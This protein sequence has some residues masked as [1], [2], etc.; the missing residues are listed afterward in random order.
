MKIITEIK[1]I[2]NLDQN[3]ADGLIFNHQYLSDTHTD[4]LTNEEVIKLVEYGK[5]N[6]KMI[7]ANVNRIFTE[8]EIQKAFEEI[9]ELLNLGVEYFVFSDVGIYQ[10]FYEKNLHHNLIYNARTM[11]TNY[12]DAQ[13]WKENGVYAYFISNEIPLEDIIEISKVGNGALNVY[14]YHQIF[15]SKR[16]LVSLYYAHRQ[17]ENRFQNH[18]LMLVEEN[19][20]KKYPITETPYGTYI[21]SPYKYAIYTE[22]EKLRSLKLILISGRFINEENLQKVI[23]LY[24]LGIEN[25]FTNENMDKL[26]KID[27][28]IHSGFLYQKTVLRKGERND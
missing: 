14:G 10:Y 11:I 1:N 16:N 8:Q 7:I 24:K 12:G 28:N 23:T 3:Q 18:E 17:M 25:G 2:S 26:R 20:P 21:Y 22:L 19:R 5:I 6:S 9:D 27:D 15:Y 4:F 13:I